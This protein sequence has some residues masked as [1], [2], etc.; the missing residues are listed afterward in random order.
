MSGI[1]S[2]SSRAIAALAPVAALAAALVAAPAAAAPQGTD[3]DFSGLP[4]GTIVHTLSPGAGWTGPLAGSIAVWGFNPLFGPAVNAAVIFDSLRPTGGD[5]DLGTPNEAYGGPGRGAAG[6]ASN[7]VPLGNVLIIDEHLTDQNKDGLVDNP[8]DADLVGMMYEFDF[9]GTSTSGKGKGKKAGTSGVV[10]VNSI[11]YLD[12]ELEQGEGG[13]FVEFWRPGQPVSMLGL[14]PTGDNGVA[15]LENIGLDGVSHM[16]VTLNG[17]SAIANVLLGAGTA[18]TCWITT[19]GFQNAGVASGGKDFT[20]GGNV[21]P[22]PSGSWQVVDHKTGDKFHSHDVH[23]V[24]CLEI[25]RTGPG[26]PGGKKGLTVNKATFEGVGRLNGVAGFPFEGF[27]IDAGEPAGKKGN[28]K[29]HFSITV[30]DPATWAVV[31]QASGD[32]DG[33]NV[34][35]HPAKP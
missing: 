29:D 19:G 33:G 30:H 7:T 35:I 1:Y 21:G 12:I 13:A 9:T 17:S 15:T 22:P 25:E 28:D 14:D 4:G 27:V 18:R 34:Q 24:E 23:I 32:L 8:D 16:R 11:T 31:F 26:Q 10:T 2:S 20:F 5:W 6:A 3:V